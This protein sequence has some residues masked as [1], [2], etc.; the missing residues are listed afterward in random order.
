MGLAEAVAR[1]A[2]DLSPVERKL[3]EALLASPGEAAVL[4][5][6]EM[7]RRAGADPA[8]AVRL[9]RKLGFSGYR[10]L[11]QSLQSALIQGADAHDRLER[12]VG[13]M[14]KDQILSTLIEVEMESLQLLRNQI[15]DA[16]LL[17][18]AA[19]L[20]DA[21]RI[22]LY[23]QGHATALVDLMAR[24]LNRHGYLAIPIR[25]GEWSAPEALVNMAS[26]DMLVTFAFYRVPPILPT[27]L[28]HAEA[29]GAS[30]LLITDL[31]GLRFP[32]MPTHTLAAVRG[33]PEQ[34]HSLTVPMLLVNALILA[35]ARFDD[36]RS[37][38]SLEKLDALT[39]QFFEDKR[40]PSVKA[41][42]LRRQI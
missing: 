37:V 38:A 3:T 15:S 8:T 12:R 33:Q 30:S 2:D 22:F 23:G 28:A 18:A 24:R 19:T 42:R 10:A 4:P 31:V 36:G 40:Y 25:E 34:S 27:M 35:I 5:V 14:D 20:R 11:K 13:P 32:A 16:R 6:A 29:V 26:T 1:H 7:A 9:A 41:A 21:R 39:H 17:A